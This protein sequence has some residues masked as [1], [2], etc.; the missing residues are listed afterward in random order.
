MK[1]HQAYKMKTFHKCQQQSE[2]NKD[3]VGS[4]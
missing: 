4:R 3:Q 2:E 1:V